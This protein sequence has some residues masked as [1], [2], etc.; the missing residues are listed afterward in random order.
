MKKV[1]LSVVVALNLFSPCYAYVESQEF[2]DE[3]QRFID[4]IVEEETKTV[5]SMSDWPLGKMSQL[6]PAFNILMPGKSIL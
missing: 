1:M 2:F 6:F 4:K 3:R 5:D